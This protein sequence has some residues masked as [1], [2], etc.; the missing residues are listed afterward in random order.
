MVGKP[1]PEFVCDRERKMKMACGRLEV[2][3]CRGHAAVADGTGR[4]FRS[5]KGGRLAPLN[6]Y[7]IMRRERQY[8]LEKDYICLNII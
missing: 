2:Q 3:D 5:G 1:R 8:P 6:N 7:K 4:V